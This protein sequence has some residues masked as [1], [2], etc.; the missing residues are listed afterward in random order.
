MFQLNALAKNVFKAPVCVVLPTDKID[1]NG[2][3]IKAEAHFIATFQSVSEDESDALVD[4]LKGV[5][6]SDLAKVSKL[7]KEQTHRVFIGFEKHPKHPFPFKLG[8][9]DVASTPENIQQ[10]LNSKEVVEAV[11]AAYNKARA[12]GVANQNLKK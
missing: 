1:D 9:T 5:D 11:R 12:G 10:L 2:E 4:Q 8:D 6:E 7:L 3:T